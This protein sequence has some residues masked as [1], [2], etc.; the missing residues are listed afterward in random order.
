MS[1]VARDPPP[2]WHARHGQWLRR[3]VE[4]ER[5]ARRAA[6]ACLMRL[7]VGVQI[8]GHIARAAATRGSPQ[9]TSSMM[10]LDDL[11]YERDFLRGELLAISE[12][13]DRELK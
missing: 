7:K 6:D 8:I 1:E 13:I 4:V 10:S 9:P 11:R 2:S 5:E 3:E 12:M